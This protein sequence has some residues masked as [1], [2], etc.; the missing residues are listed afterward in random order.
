M[1]A[2]LEKVKVVTPE[3]RVSYPAV[4]EP[5]QFKGQKDA[6]Y[7]VTMI[8]DKAIDL[9][10]L[11]K[12][13]YC[14]KVE[15]WGPDKTKHPKIKHPLFRDG[16]E[17]KGDVAGYQDSIFCVAKSKEQPGLVNSRRQAI[18]SPKDFYAGCYARAEVIAYAYDNEFGKGVGLSLQ[19]IQKLR[20]GDKLSGKKDAEDVFDAVEDGSDDEENYDEDDEGM[21]F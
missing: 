20:D 21:G 11:K 3:F 14:A 4:F 1:A 2:N 12:A 7:G 18:V 16:D 5:K 6:K 9:S 8:F 19:N 10:G 15:K 13:V 17:E